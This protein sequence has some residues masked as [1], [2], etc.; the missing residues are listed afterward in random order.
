MYFSLVFAGV[1][2]AV[3]GWLLRGRLPRFGTALIGAGAW[4]CIGLAGWQLVGSFSGGGFTVTHR[5]QS[6]LAYVTAQR[7]LQDLEVTEGNVT[8][9]FPPDAAAENGALDSF[10][11]AFARVLLRSPK[12]RIQ[13]VSL[14][15]SSREARRGRIPFA[16]F[17]EA[18]ESKPQSAALVSC[19]GWPAEGERLSVMSRVP[20]PNLYVYDPFG[21]TNWISALKAGLINLVVI[22]RT[23]TPAS[24]G[25]PNVGDPGT[26]FRRDFLAITP[27][28]VNEFISDLQ[29]R[30]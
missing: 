4:G 1:A 20:R 27:E 16:A 10:Y 22:P 13:E 12:L 14:R 25:G 23:G 24:A 29:L 3:V 7:M 9:I 15:L 5:S 19:V 17:E 18:A 2:V 8:L 21:G 28:T 30:R 26:I 6:A 11:E